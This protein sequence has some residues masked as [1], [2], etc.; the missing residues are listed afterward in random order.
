[1]TGAFSIEYDLSRQSIVYREAAR[2][3][4]IRCDVDEGWWL[5][6]DT[7][8]WWDRDGGHRSPLSAAE[9]ETVLARVLADGRARGRW[10]GLLGQPRPERP[11][12]P[13]DDG[14]PGFLEG[15]APPV[16]L[17]DTDLL[18]A[19]DRVE[20]ELAPLAPQWDVAA[21]ILRQLRW[22]RGTVRGQPVEPPPGPL[23]MGLMATREFDMYGSNPELAARINRIQEAMEARGDAPR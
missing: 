19:I 18:A 2:R 23:S 10:I 17:P 6:A 16:G 21:S 8:T 14:G 9:R 3:V 12:G 15:L 7:A 1:M 20:A 11:A 13:A 22:C 4:E 5:R